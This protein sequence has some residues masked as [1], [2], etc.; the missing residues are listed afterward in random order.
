MTTFP[1]EFDF[2]STDIWTHVVSANRALAELKAMVHVLPNPNI[3]F[4]TLAVQEAINSSEIEGIMT[5]QDE[6]H[7]VDSRH[8]R[9]SESARAVDR[10][11][12]AVRR[13]LH[14][15]EHSHDLTE[16]IVIEM[17]RLLIQASNDYRD[18]AGTVVGDSET[19]QA[20]HIPPQ[21]YD[22]IKRMMTELFTFISDDGKN[23]E[24]DPLVKLALIHKQFENIHPFFGGNGRV[25][26]MLNVLYL[27]HVGLLDM[28]FLNMSL[29]IRDT[30]DEYYE[31][32]KAAQIDDRWDEWVL[33]IMRVIENAAIETTTV[34]CN[35]RDLIVQFETSMRDEYK[36]DFYSKKLLNTLF[37]FPY[38]RIEYVMDATGSSKSTAL[39]QLE[40]L[41]LHGFVDHVQVGE[42]TYYVNSQLI[43]LLEQNDPHY[44]EQSLKMAMQ[45]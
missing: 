18:I 43:A 14:M 38:S 35:I 13:G 4:T 23:G 24:L 8:N 15:W 39:K 30:K 6:V 2:N 37:A 31:L 21:G 19:G 27:C 32:L 33:Y 7:L 34:V 25:G 10:Y 36:F 3:L 41:E 42:D 20:I 5:T 28:P 1:P 12:Q 26:R 17:Y 44:R 29:H 11:T 45:A 40:Q 9:G 16:D 22:E